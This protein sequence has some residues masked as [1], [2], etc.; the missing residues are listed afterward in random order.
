MVSTRCRGAMFAVASAGS[1]NTTVLGTVSLSSCAVIWGFV[2][3][4]VAVVVMDA[5]AAA[6]VVSKRVVLL[7]GCDVVVRYIFVANVIYFFV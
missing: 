7:G 2:V 4:L 6:V 3:V 1:F 5:A